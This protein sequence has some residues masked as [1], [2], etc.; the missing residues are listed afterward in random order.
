M[1][2][3]QL[4][5]IV[6]SCI[7]VLFSEG[8]TYS[9]RFLFDEGSLVGHGLWRVQSVRSYDDEGTYLACPDALDEGYAA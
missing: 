8:C 6:V 4:G 7:R 1:D 2:V 9:S 3:Q 5:D